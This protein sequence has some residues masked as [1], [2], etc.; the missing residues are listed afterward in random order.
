VGVLIDSSCLI[1]LER[2]DIRAADLPRENRGISVISMSEI[3]HGVHRTDGAHRARREAWIERFLSGIT[4]VQITPA[5]A[6]VHSYVWSYLG[7]RGEMVGQHDLWIGATALTYDIGVVT[8]N[9]REF[10]RIP[11]L[12]VVTA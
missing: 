12:R 6:R 9:L 1:A 7:R 2:G 11:G 4:P 3:L 5:I 8:R 10:E